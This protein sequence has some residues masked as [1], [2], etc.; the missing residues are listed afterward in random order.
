MAL[1]GIDVSN[2]QKGINLSVVPADF[3][4]I[5]ATEGTNYTSGDCDR[6]YQQAKK[7][8]RLLGVY[9]YASGGN[10]T[11]EADYFLNAVKGYIGEAILCL[12]W[13]SQGN[14]VF[15]T[16]RDSAWVKQWCDYVYKKTGVK[17]IVYVQASAI[18]RV[19]SAGYGLWVAQYANNNTT[20][21]QSNPWNEGAYQCVIRQY[22]SAGKLNGYSGRLDMN[23]FY[24][25]KA[26][27]LSYAGKSGS[28]G[29]TS[30]SATSSASIAERKSGYMFNPSVVRKGS[31]GTS[32]LLVQEILKA[33]GFKGADGKELALDQHAG[34]NTIYAINSYQ[35]ARRRQGVELG[36]NGKNDSSCGPKMWA[37]LIAI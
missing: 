20:G 33:R 27:W 30:N 26:L 14:P 21:Y 32:V 23:K 24:G 22:S 2:W 5:K 15:N 35:T 36:T 4:I 7:A 19:K 17:P 1:N 8:G 6:Q 34:D 12:D 18:S 3:V 31:K 16:G 10:V 25:D 11:K 9:H 37:D 29:T 13:E 28:N